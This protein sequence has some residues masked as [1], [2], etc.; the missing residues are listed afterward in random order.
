MADNPLA[1]SGRF[2]HFVHKTAQW[3]N[4][5]CNHNSSLHGGHFPLYSA[6]NTCFLLDRDIELVLP[7]CWYLVVFY[8]ANIYPRSLFKLIKIKSIIVPFLLVLFVLGKWAWGPILG[9]VEARE[10]G[11]REAIAV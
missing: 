7:T 1:F 5:F 11:I 4:F 8:L 3:G 2:D 6:S 10:D 9:A